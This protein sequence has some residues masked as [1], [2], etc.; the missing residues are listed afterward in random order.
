MIP[1]HRLAP[2]SLAFALATACA[3]PPDRSPAS[4]AQLATSRSAPDVWLDAP[5]SASAVTPPA[6]PEPPATSAGKDFA[7][8]VRLLFH[9]V[10]CTGEAPIPPSLDAAA[11][12][13]HCAD[14]QPKIEAYRTGYVA[15]A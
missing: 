3:P 11:I 2:L 7:D 5:P 14:L 15:K 4:R 8:E 10:T 1:L 6:P 13:A 9:L 12:K